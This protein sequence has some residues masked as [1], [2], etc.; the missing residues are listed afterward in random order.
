MK[1]ML[2]WT[3]DAIIYDD[4]EPLGNRASTT[5]TLILP[6]GL[7]F[8]PNRGGIVIKGHRLSITHLWKLARELKWS[9]GYI[10]ECFGVEESEVS[11]AVDFADRHPECIEP[12]GDTL[13]WMDLS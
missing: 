8:A 2:C 3:P 11:V 5:G 13:F 7:E 12:D 10:A 6:R 9:D 4:G 1:T